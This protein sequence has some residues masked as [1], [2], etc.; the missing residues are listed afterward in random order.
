[1]RTGLIIGKF[2]P[3]HRGHKYVIDS[4]AAACDHVVV[5]VCDDPAYG[6]AADLRASWLQEIHPA[7]QVRVIADLGRDDDSAAWAAHTLD[8]FRQHGLGTIDGV[9]TSESYGEAYA[10]ALGCEHVCVDPGRERY[11]VSARQVRAQ[12]LAH[13]DMLE[14]CVR[15][16]YAVRVC[17]MGA[18]STGTTTLAQALAAHYATVW[19][20]EF[21]RLYAEGKLAGSSPWHSAEFDYI[22]RQQDAL[23]DQYL[24]VC[25]KLLV[26]D[27]NSLATE[28]WH[29]RYVGSPRVLRGAD[30][31]YDLY[32]LTAPD[33]AFVQDG[34]R[35]GCHLREWMH[36]RFKEVL[37]ESGVPYITLSGT[38]EQRFATAIQHCDALLSVSG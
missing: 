23:E 29:E 18:E 9:Y 34:F 21:G 19:V 22:A 11:P 12:P 38:P 17:V 26:C 6:M 31:R 14:P 30:R 7:A 8:F 5:L 16:H 20:P 25:H 35:D 1:V 15:A 13:W 10:K 32:F 36:G 24:R 33:I 28:V 27:T 3:P 4:A 37:E 2:L